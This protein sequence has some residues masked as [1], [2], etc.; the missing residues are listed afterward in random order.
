MKKYLRILLMCLIMLPYTSIEV[1]TI[2]SIE[3]PVYYTTIESM[4]IV[5][6]VEVPKEISSTYQSIIFTNY[7]TGDATNSSNITSAGLTTK[8][9]RVNEKGWYTYKGMVVVA[10]AT[11]LC[12]RVK[13]GGC[14]KYNVVPKGLRLFDLR[15]E[16][17]ISI[18]GKEYKAIVLDSCGACMYFHS[19]DK[20]LQRF[21][22]FIANSKYSFGKIE[23][24]LITK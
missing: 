8:S 14:G 2:P 5:E 21:D 17:L 16:I 24:K 4:D 23:G 18:G 15:E 7:Y 9:F 22:I 6:P 19:I 12:L 13:S 10:A 1:G 11:T 20:D 3:Q